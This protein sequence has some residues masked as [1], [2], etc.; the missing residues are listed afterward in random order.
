MADEKAAFLTPLD[1]GVLDMYDPTL[2]ANSVDCAPLDDDMSNN[3]A[4]M[5]VRF[6]AKNK[7]DARTPDKAPQVRL[8]WKQECFT[9]GDKKQLWKWASGKPITNE[10][11]LAV[12]K[13]PITDIAL[14]CTRSSINLTTFAPY[15]DTVN[16]DT[17]LGAGPGFV[18]FVTASANPRQ[19]E[20]STSVVYDVE[21]HLEFRSV[22]TWNKVW[23]EDT[24]AWEEQ[25]MND[26]T[27]IYAPA[28]YADLLAA[29]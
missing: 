7:G 2:K 28:A 4:V 5:T 17:F 12:V 14:L 6:V 19:R 1:G 25:V 3:K 13:V 11:A 16:S 20:R 26:G 22:A 15:Q 27:K 10:K 29:P 18:R 21:I 23:N 24:S 8:S 9:R